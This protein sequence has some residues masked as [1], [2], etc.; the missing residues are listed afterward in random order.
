[1]CWR[2]WCTV[3][4]ERL[5]L[6][7]LVWVWTFTH[8]CAFVF[9]CVCFVFGV[10]D[11]WTNIH[12]AAM[13]AQC[14]FVCV[15][16]CVCVFVS[17]PEP[18]LWH[19]DSLCPLRLLRRQL[20]Q[21]SSYQHDKHHPDQTHAYLLSRGQD[22]RADQQKKL[23]RSLHTRRKKLWRH[24]VVPLPTA[25]AKEAPALLHI[26]HYSAWMMQASIGINPGSSL[27]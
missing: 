15:C 4:A 17:L 25:R 16:V 13:L 23:V 26:S 8:E 12:L 27:Y 19:N 1:M 20:V 22:S 3:S 24:C 10:L 6:L 5:C 9:G 21:R 7:L 11:N 14:A 18:L 2:Q